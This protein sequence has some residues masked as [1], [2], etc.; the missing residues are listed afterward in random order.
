MY[1][2]VNNMNQSFGSL[3]EKELQ[4]QGYPSLTPN[5]ISLFDKNNS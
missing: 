4:T 1:T 3:I 2:T 5:E